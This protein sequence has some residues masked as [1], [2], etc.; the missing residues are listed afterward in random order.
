MENEIWKDI[1]GYEG[2]YQASNLGRIKSIRKNII[3]KPCLPNGYVQVRLSKNG[4]ITNLYVHRLVWEAFNGKI[5]E[6]MQVNH[7]NEVKNDN[8]LINLNLMSRTENLNWGTCQIR[9][10]IKNINGKKSKVIYQ[11]DLYNKLIK[12]WPS[13]MEIKRKLSYSTGNIYLCCK[14]NRKSAYGY[15]WKFKEDC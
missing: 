11:F 4:I 5:P 9:R 13:I 8:R 12:E 3:L 2:L 15:I 14:N 10:S 7:I 1:L 6:E